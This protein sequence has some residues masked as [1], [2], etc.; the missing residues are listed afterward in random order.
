MATR[1]DFHIH[2][3]LSACAN[4]NMTLGAIVARARQVGLDAIGISDHLNRP[5]Q[6]AAN[7]ALLKEIRAMSAAGGAAH[8]IYFG[9]EVGFSAKLGRHPL[10]LD[11]KRELGYQYA[12]G[13]HHSPYIDAYDP[14]KLIDQQHRH[15][16]LTCRD[17]AMDVLGHP[18]RLLYEEFQAR[19]WPW[20]CAIEMVPRGF[21]RELGQAARD[22]GTA[23]EINTT[24]NL[25]MKFNPPEYFERYVDYLAALA[26]EGPMFALGSDAHEIEEI[27]TI[28]LAWQVA[29]RLNLRPERIWRPAAWA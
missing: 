26:D 7:A 9:A 20:F 10:T 5:E 2:T 4:R 3:N 28:A 18:Y 11:L 19:G 15:H 23:I 6:A 16:L 14:V 22:S 21:I 27:D 1:F 13:S 29:D 8:T 24:S 17:E 12:I 25:A